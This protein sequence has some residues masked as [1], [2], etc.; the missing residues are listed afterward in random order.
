M[1]RRRDESYSRGST[2]LGLCIKQDN[3][4]TQAHFSVSIHAPE[5]HFTDRFIPACTIPGSLNYR[6]Q[7][8]LANL[9][10]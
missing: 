6:S 3:L 7:D 2:L 8:R 5:C 10:E 4:F 1:S 9:R